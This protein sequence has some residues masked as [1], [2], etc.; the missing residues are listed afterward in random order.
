MLVSIFWI[1]CGLLL[2]VYVLYPL[3][4]GSLAARFGKAVKRGDALPS[5]TIVV[6]AYNEEK[7]I[8]AKLDNLTAL[9][10]PAALVDVIVASDGST[11]ATEEL[12]A[13]FPGRI[14][15]LRVEGRCGKTACQNA[16]ALAAS[17]D[18]VVFT[19]ATTRLHPAALRRL[20]ENFADPQVGCA[21]GRLVYVTDIENV[22]GR[23]GE[24]YWSYELRLRAAESSLGSLIGVSGCLYAVRKAAYRPIDPELISDFVVSMMMRE[25]NLR[26]V[27]APDA[28]CFEETLDQGSQELSMRVRVAVRSLNALI[29]ERRFLNPVRYGLFAWQLWSHK[30]LRY[31][32]PILWL[33]ALA[34]NVALARDAP[35]LCLLLAQCA[36]LAAG[37]VGFALQGSRRDLGLFGRPYYFLLTNVASLIAT[38]R[39]LKGERMVTWKP[40]R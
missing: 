16:A 39:Y 31:A 4:V 21:G 27:L 3:L 23:G 25:Q 33:G 18:V 36:L 10:Y 12:A 29:R 37:S 7:C 14:S 38:L 26:T 2:Y 24:A 20:V 40:I 1:C 8:Q 32:S 5:I 35:Y 6:T 34:T 15:V 9:S 17:G 11:D 13:A 22:T 30:V 19:D 28:V